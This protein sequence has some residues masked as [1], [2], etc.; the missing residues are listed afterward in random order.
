MRTL[1]DIPL[2][3]DERQALQEAATILTQRFPVERVILY[4]SKARGEADD[5]SDID[6]VLLMA[7]RL[8]WREEQAIVSTLFDLGMKYD[9]LFS[10]LRVPTEEWNGGIFTEFP[11][12][13]EILRDGA[14]VL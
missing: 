12:Y 5:Y 13:Q 11:I 2:L 6:L 9:M 1:E 8:N 7:S 4:G 3:P 10:S 14:D